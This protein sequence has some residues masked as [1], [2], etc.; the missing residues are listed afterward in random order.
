MKLF[1]LVALSLPFVA[2]T[3]NN[4]G[5]TVMDSTA[6]EAAEPVAKGRWVCNEYDRSNESLKQRTAILS[7]NGTQSVLELYEGAAVSA[8]STH[9]GK[10][11]SEDVNVSFASADGKV[12]FHMFLDEM[13]ESGLTLD[14]AA[15]GDFVC[16]EAN[17]V[18][19]KNASWSCTDYDRESN[20][21]GQKTVVLTQTD[22]KGLVEGQ[23]L[24][25]MMET[26]AGAQTFTDNG[27]VL[28]V[29]LTEDVQ[30]QFSSEDGAVKFGIFLDEMNESSLTLDGSTKS[31][32]ICR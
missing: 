27:E 21:L 17:A 2:C 29:V 13:A 10:I 3:P 5:S 28:G 31:D 30:V 11:E 8:V 1:A 18:E 26:Y 9:E 19:T 16:R 32:F 20:K 22:G 23:E 14:G 7:Q 4:S 25:F 12:G 24:A 15:A 6:S